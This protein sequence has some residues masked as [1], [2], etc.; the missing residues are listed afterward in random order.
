MSGGE[1]AIRSPADLDAL[2]F[3]D[4]GLIPV[5]AQDAATGAVLM[6]A[7]A[8]RAALEHTLETG[9]MYYHSRSRN[10]LWK[11]GETSGNVQ[12]VVS[13]HGDCD[14]DTLLARVRQSG[15]AC[16]TGTATCFGEGVGGGSGAGAERPGGDVLAELQATL[17]SRLRDRPEGSYTSKLL[18]DE[19]LRVKKLGEES[20]E[21]IA[22]LT[23]GDPGVTEEAADLVYHL[24]VALLA[25][26]RSWDEVLDALRRRQG[27]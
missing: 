13:L 23:R 20:A 21:L 24:M 3:D 2:V 25:A 5:V 27:K 14:G 15:K 16:H 11:K 18:S 26:G 7:W 19:N 10:E 12:E 17:E 6:L 8:N 9:F 4:R 1:R 22:A